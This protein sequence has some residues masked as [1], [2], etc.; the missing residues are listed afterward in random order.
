[1]E[2]MLRKQKKIWKIEKAITRRK[3][4]QNEIGNG[5]DHGKKDVTEHWEIMK[6]DLMI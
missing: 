6:M 2:E 3:C 4:L 5:L 1:M